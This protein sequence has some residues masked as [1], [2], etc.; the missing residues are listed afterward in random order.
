MAIQEI[1]DLTSIRKED[2]ISTLQHLQVINYY[3]GQHVIVLSDEILKKHQTSLEKRIVRIDPS[4]LRWTP[5]DW[6]KSSRW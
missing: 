6:S 4:R 1:C 2:A 3:K 5:K